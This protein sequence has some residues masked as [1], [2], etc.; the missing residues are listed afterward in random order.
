MAAHKGH[1]KFGGR[2]KGTPNK[3]TQDLFE[4]C[5][6]HNVDVFESM[7][8][9]AASEKIPDKKFEKMVELAPYLYAKRKAVEVSNDPEGDG[10]VVRIME[11]G[12]EKK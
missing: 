2:Q 1:K 3:S 12:Q 9:L 10:F 6:K 4:I 7:V 11:F 8:I 5:K